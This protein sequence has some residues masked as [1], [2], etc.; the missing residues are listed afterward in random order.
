MAQEGDIVKDKIRVIYTIAVFT[1][2]AAFDNVVLGLFPPLFLTISRDLK[3]RVSTLGMMSA[4]NIFV[5]SVSSIVWGYLSG[6]YNRKRLIMV[7]TLIWSIAVYGTSKSL[8]ITQL[9]TSQIATGIGLG[10]IGSIGFSVLTDYIPSRQR[11]VMLSLWGLSQ[12]FGGIA[13]ALMASLMASSGDWRRPFRIVSITGIILI[14]FYFFIRE[15][16]VGESEPE[17]KE[18]YQKGKDYKYS[19]EFSHVSELVFKRSNLLLFVQSL[20]FN[21]TTGTLIWLPTLYNAKLRAQG[22]PLETAIIASGYLYG[23]FQIGGLTSSWFGYIG[24]RFQRRNFRARAYITATLIVMAV[25]FYTAVFLIPMRGIDLGRS[26]NPLSVFV[27]LTESFIK[28][29]YMAAMFI[30]AFFASA[31]QS[32]NTPNYLALIT[33]VNLPEHRGTVFS[34]SNLMSGLGR[35]AGNAG[36]SFVLD[37]MEVYLKEP[38]SYTAALLVFQLFFIPASLCYLIMA[39]NNAEDIKNVKETLKKRGRIHS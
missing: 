32:S 14:I 7:G 24:D 39:K 9:Y 8:N 28:N 23:I 26:G 25:P 3:V 15:P 35:T 11:G 31:C 1:V 38:L 29:P 30:L 2:L 36:I 27:L 22:Y 12:G 37:F 34:I 16:D 18:L 19:M 17:L 21:I 20:L 6:K 10:C 5:I 13:G 33:D 4:L